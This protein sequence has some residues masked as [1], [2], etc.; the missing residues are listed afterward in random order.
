MSDRSLS[1][2]TYLGDHRILYSGDPIVRIINNN[3][4]QQ[5]Q[6]IHIVFK[7]AYHNI[8]YSS[9]LQHNPPIQLYSTSSII[10]AAIKEATTMSSQHAKKCCAKHLCTAPASITLGNHRCCVCKGSAHSV[11]CMTEVLELPQDIR[12]IFDSHQQIGSFKEVCKL[13]L[14]QQKSS[15][16]ASPE[17]KVTQSK[18]LFSSKNSSQQPKKT[19]AVT[20]KKAKEIKTFSLKEKKQILDLVKGSDGSKGTMSVKEACNKFGCSRQSLNKWSKKRTEI[21]EQAEKNGTFT[22]VIKNDPLERVKIGIKEFFELNNKMI[23]H[24]KIN[25]TGKK[26]IGM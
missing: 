17:K 12:H 22:K 3:N 21:N 24:T 23:H 18:L 9:S 20:K 19:K 11:F 8:H 1:I 2:L 16:S 7:F 15:V 13:C 25:I 14:E 5:K 4:Q 10:L 6:H 26:Y